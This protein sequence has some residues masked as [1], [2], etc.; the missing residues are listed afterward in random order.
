V[1][2]TPQRTFVET[3]ARIAGIAPVFVPVPRD[4][5]FAAGGQ[6]LGDHL[7]FGEYLDLP[8][9]TEIVE[10]VTQVLGVTPTPLE[11]ALEEGFRWYLSQPRRPVDYTF[12]DRLISRH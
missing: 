11:T 1:E 8:P 5:I 7:Y 4:A 12:E 2:P 10:K 3:L 9:H 6:L